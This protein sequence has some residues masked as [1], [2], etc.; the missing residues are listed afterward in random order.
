MQL[1]PLLKGVHMLYYANHPKAVTVLEKYRLVVISKTIIL[2]S[3]SNVRVYCFR[4]QLN[5]FMES[6]GAPI[7]GFRTLT[8]GLSKPFRRLE[9]YRGL[10]LELEHHIEV[11]YFD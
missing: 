8:A 4:D 7:P 3:I 1:A 9:K 6:H 2:G 11:R 10:L 5:D